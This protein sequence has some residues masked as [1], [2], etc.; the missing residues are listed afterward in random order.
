MCILCGRSPG[1]CIISSLTKAG[2]HEGALGH[3]L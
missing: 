3:S 2:T 1:I